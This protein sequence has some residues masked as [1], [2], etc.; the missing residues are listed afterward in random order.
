MKKIIELDGIR[1]VA[2]ALV[3]I[4]HYFATQ[5]WVQDGTLLYYFRYMSALTWSGVDLFFVLSGFLIG[6]ILLDQRGRS[7]YFS[8]FFIRRICRIFP[9]YFMV[10][11]LF[12]ILS[13]IVPS[14]LRWLFNDPYPLWTYVTFTQNY[15]MGGGG[16]GSDW[17]GVTWSLA[18]EEQ[19][20]LVLPFLVFY[21]RGKWFIPILV[22]MIIG[23]PVA[24][25]LVDGMGSYIYTFCRADSLMSGVL[26]AWLVRRNGFLEFTQK[27]CHLVITT[28]FILLLIIA[29]LT[30]LV[31]QTGDVINHFVF[32]IFYVVFILLATIYQGA[33]QAGILRNSFLCWLGSR[34]Y[35][36]YLLH[37]G[38]SATVHAMN[39]NYPPRISNY[40]E[41]F[42]TLSALLIT[43]VLAELSFRYYESPLIKLGHKLRYGSRL[44][45]R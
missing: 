32:A 10:L 34:S 42:I 5:L 41:A 37:Q 26:L 2:I 25:Y 16:F 8:T 1:G 6:G 39:G 28:F 36:I 19:F 7:H 15:L 22:I 29:Y 18:I 35:G 14:G 21:I 40:G 44:I 30:F 33:P 13:K 3:L 31:T 9:L 45:D 43:L 17:L 38:I 20:Y 24:R 12:V 11:L 23:S 4:W 27:Y